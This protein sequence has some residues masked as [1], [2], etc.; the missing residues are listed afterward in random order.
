MCPRNFQWSTLFTIRYSAIPVVSNHN[1]LLDLFVNLKLFF[2]GK[3]AK[4]ITISAESTVTWHY[5]LR[6]PETRD[7]QRTS[8]S[9]C[10][11]QYLRWGLNHN[12]VSEIILGITAAGSNWQKISTYKWIYNDLRQPPV[13]QLTP[14]DTIWQD[15]EDQL[16][17]GLTANGNGVKAKKYRIFVELSFNRQVIVEL[18]YNRQV[19]H[20]HVSDRREA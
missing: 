19:P 2:I 1:L 15:F 14:F 18:S 16:Y 13:I 12:L 20:I 7:R 17:G 4:K 9:Q 6:V 10:L 8:I 3:F 11:K 5:C